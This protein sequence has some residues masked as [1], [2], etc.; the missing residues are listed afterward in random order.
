MLT[1]AKQIDA[2]RLRQRYATHAHFTA[3]ALSY[4]QV[5]FADVALDR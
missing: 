3:L 2:S 4:Q 1:R 5:S